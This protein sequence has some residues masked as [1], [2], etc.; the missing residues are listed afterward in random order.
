MGKKYQVVGRALNPPA[1]LPDGVNVGDEV[2]LDLSK[3]R[4]Q[5][6]TEA[7]VVQAVKSSSSKDTAKDPGKKD[8]SKDD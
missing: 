8:E 3:D 4:E 5:A 2:E 7:G 1:E 6:L